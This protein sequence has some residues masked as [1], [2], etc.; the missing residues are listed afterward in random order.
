M[1]KYYS[2]QEDMTDPIACL[3]NMEKDTMYF[4][5][6][7]QQPDKEELLREIVKEVNGQCDRD[8][9]KIITKE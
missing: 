8:H 2:S 5:Q 1:Y 6:H 7:L 4:H 3:S 9:W